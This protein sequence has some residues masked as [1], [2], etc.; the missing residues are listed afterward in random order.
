M[1]VVTFLQRASESWATENSP[2]HHILDFGHQYNVHWSGEVHAPPQLP[3]LKKL[4]ED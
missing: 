2:K 1:S 3:R 4:M